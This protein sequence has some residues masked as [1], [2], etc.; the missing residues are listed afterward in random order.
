MG[1]L[2]KY[3]WLFPVLLLIALGLG[4]IG[5][6]EYYQRSGQATTWFTC[7][8][9]SLQLFVL[10]SGGVFG[11]LPVLLEISRFMA[12]AVTAGGILLAIWEPFYKNYLLFKIH[13]WKNHI[14]VCGL[15]KKAELLIEDFLR[16]AD[17]KM[18]IV[19]IDPNSQ[20]ASLSKLIK[21]G[22]IYL[23]GNATDE[24]E[25]MKAN[26]LHA[27]FL[28]AL[29]N[30][31]KINIQIAQKA[32]HL[33]NQFPKK[34]LP[35]T[36][37]Q[38]ILHIDD[39]YTM[40][41]FKEFHEKA[42]PEE[43]KYRPA[44][45]KM[46]YHVFS[47]FQLAATY[48]VD[49]YSP[50]QY[51]DLRELEDPPAH[52]LIL[53]DTLTIEFLILEAAHMFHFANLKKTK[54]TVVSDDITRLTRKMEVIYPSLPETVEIQYINTAQFF[55]EQCPI[56][57]NEISVCYMSLED[58]GKSVY[59]ARKLRQFIYAQRRL[60]NVTNSESLTSPVIADFRSPPIKVLLPRNTALVH[61]F[62]DIKTELNQLDIELMNMDHQLCNKKTIVD[63]RKSEDFIA[64]HMHYEWAKI[65]AK[66]YGLSLGT[67]D[68]EWDNLK[69]AQKDSNRLPAR[70]LN[71]KLRF[72][73]A[74]FTDQKDG[75]EWNIDTIDEATWDR[76]ARIEHNR[77]MAEKYLNG[78]VHIDAVPDKELMEL[79]NLTLKC[80][81]DIVPFDQLSKEIQSY[82][83]FTF[84]MA[85]EIARLN[86]K[87]IV[88]SQQ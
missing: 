9:L 37:L 29:T 81:P 27:K 64:E 59:F 17:G 28:L 79:L 48:L 87:R 14:V 71:I 75:E 55:I 23:E 35:D 72:V 45:S 20:H 34:I 86:N 5:F 30:D 22:V 44:G 60:K 54:I 50:D 47:I 67:M 85:P 53:G 8:Y 11:K 78:F 51:V 4:T 31:E 7:I 13:H 56:D 69:D 74:E 21:K 63:D 3:N 26:I 12:P 66:K 43:A 10:N 15:S 33:Y 1:T 6:H 68:S 83:M 65:H 73:Q 46:D 62:S 61:I 49:H 36:I 57:C 80:H 16:Q 82:D 77:W 52:I 24:E 70:H 58:D 84:R 42:V 32:T 40:N 76:I 88:K 41:I 19:L 25:L 39:F 2:K 18:N 38:V